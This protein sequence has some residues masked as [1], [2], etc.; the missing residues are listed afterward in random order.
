MVK[1]CGMKKYTLVFIIALLIAGCSGDEIIVDPTTDTAY[2][3]KKID[4]LAVELVGNTTKKMKNVAVL[5]FANPD[6][7]VSQLGQYLATKFS[8]TASKNRL[9]ISPSKGEIDEAIKKEGID[10]Q[11]SLD[12][13]SA[14][15]LGRALRVDSFVVGVLSDLQKGSDIDLMVK[16]IEARSGNM[17]SAANTNIFRSKSVSSLMQSF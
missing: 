6:G 1:V 8:S 14:S 9:F 16:V 5:G 7:R 17:I 15:K 2:F 10:Y 13:A 3:D 11:G 12:R 4:D